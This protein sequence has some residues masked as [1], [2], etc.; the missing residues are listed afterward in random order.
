MSPHRAAGAILVLDSDAL[1]REVIGNGLA[2]LSCTVV[3]TADSDEALQTLDSG[4]A[5]R[6]LITSV[7]TKGRMNGLE[8][9]RE[10]RRR[11]PDLTVI[12]ASSD[13]AS[14]DRSGLDGAILLPKPFRMNQLLELVATQYGEMPIVPIASSR[15]AVA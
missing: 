12:V 6:V 7:R 8:L 9:A 5:P 2:L 13:V 3:L 1:V 15:F 11:D 10:A 4:L 14:V